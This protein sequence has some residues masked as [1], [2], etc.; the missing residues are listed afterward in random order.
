MQFV[1]PELGELD[2]ERYMGKALM[3]ADAA[4]QAGLMQKMVWG[5]LGF[6]KPPQAEVQQ[7]A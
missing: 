2:L 6:S 5:R 4:G 1:S 3:E 7:E